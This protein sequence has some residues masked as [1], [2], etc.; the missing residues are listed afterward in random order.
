MDDGLEHE[1]LPGLVW[2]PARPLGAP[3]PAVRAFVYR[4]IIAGAVTMLIVNLLFIDTRLS[5]SMAT[6][7]AG[8]AISCMSVL[9]GHWV[10]RLE[11]DVD[12]EC[13]AAQAVRELAGAHIAPAVQVSVNDMGYAEV[14]AAVYAWLQP[15]TIAW[16]VAALTCVTA[17]VLGQ[18]LL[19]VVELTLAGLP[20][21]GAL[22]L[23][24][25]ARRTAMKAKW[26]P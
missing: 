24:Y 13:T 7:L 20:I 1:D 15:V 26:G 17:A 18:R 3:A 5:S 12:M 6:A 23:A 4:M 25:R 8:A 21:A 11:A 10:R 19:L 22:L 9:T 16:L 2:R 14:P